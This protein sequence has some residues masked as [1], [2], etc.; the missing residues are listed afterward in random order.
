MT[1]LGNRVKVRWISGEK[2]FTL[3]EVIVSLVLAGIVGAIAVM[4]TV[5]V[6]KGYVFTKV[7]SA[8]SQK[9]QAAMVRIVKELN[10]V[11]SVTSGNANRITFNSYRNGALVTHT[12]SWAGTINNPLLL[13]GDVLMDRV[14][15]FV[16]AYY[17]TY[18]SQAQSNWS[19]SRRLIEV[20]LSI[21]GADNVS[22]DFTAR[23]VPRNR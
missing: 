13:D 2:G 11:N 6:V 5:S 1:I 20:T 9:G 4:G 15:N 17:D 8:T 21:Q 22:S 16:M 10:V 12:I 18:N 7:N 19:S 14:S 3:I 23:V